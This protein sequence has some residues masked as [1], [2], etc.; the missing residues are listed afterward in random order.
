M[1]EPR[2]ALRGRF[3]RRQIC[4]S[5]SVAELIRRRG[6][7]AGLIFERLILHG[8]DDGRFIAEP[9]VVKAHCLP[10]HSR[11]EKQIAADLEA[12]VE[13]ELLTIYQV[14]DTAYGHFPGWT[15]HQPKSK[16]DRYIPSELPAPPVLQ[17]AGQFGTEPEPTRSAEAVAVAKAVGEDEEEGQAVAKAEGGAGGEADRQPASDPGPAGREHAHISDPEGNGNGRKPVMAHPDE[18]NPAIPRALTIASRMKVN[19]RDFFCVIRSDGQQLSGD[20]IREQAERFVEHYFQKGKPDNP[21]AAWRAWIRD[22]V[23]HL[24]GPSRPSDVDG[25]SLSW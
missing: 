1:A 11:S 17:T 6:P 2:R 20:M 19:S 25:G 15:R 9:S 7:W 21:G 18:N 13:L 16:A 14:G 3:I 12:M 10:W 4:E 24:A 8:D 23:A 5:K 22:Q